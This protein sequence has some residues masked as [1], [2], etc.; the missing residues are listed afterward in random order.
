MMTEAGMNKKFF[1]GILFFGSVWGAAEAGLGGVLYRMKIISSSVP[2]TVIA[3][4]ILTV[5]KTYFPQKYSATCIGFVAMLYKF[6]NTPLFLCHLLAIFL[7]GAAYDLCYGFFNIKS[8]AVF[9]L[10]A[11]YLGYISFA[12][13]ITYVFRYHY[14]TEGSMHKILRYAGIS[15]T[16]AAVGN[17]IAV[18]LAHKLGQVL[19]NRAENPFDLRLEPVSGSISVIT[20]CLWIPVMLR[21]L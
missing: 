18:P 1:L 13:T 14:W 4:V 2:L 8:R 19:I 12:L 11:T 20:L 10:A 9:G 6:L 5:A 16:L 21:W 3:F 15:G 7:L 17:F